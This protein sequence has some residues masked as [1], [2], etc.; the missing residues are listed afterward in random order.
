MR[1]SGTE[2]FVPQFRWRGQRGEILVDVLD[3][4][5]RFV[6]NLELEALFTDPSRQATRVR[7][8]QV[9]PGRYQGAF[10]VPQAGRYFVTLS[11]RDGDAQVGPKTF[12]L[13]V[14]Y[15][16]EYL[17]LGVDQRLLRDV[18]GATG[19]RVLAL[20]EASLGAVTA[21]APQAPSLLATRIWWPLFL[22]ALVL[23]IAEVA[24]RKVAVPDA[25]RARWRAAQAEREPEEPE[26]EA[27]RATIARERARHLAAIRD[28]V[29]LSADDPAVRARLYLSAGRARRR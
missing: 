25:W 14:P 26:Y 17:R 1:R 3:H 28:G 29:T 24:V 18:A 23:L 19:G 16:S 4:D 9:A 27:L 11:G 12:G 7:L 5:D 6:N 8:E 20:S 10:A 15:S 13:A 21:P 2:H 22:A